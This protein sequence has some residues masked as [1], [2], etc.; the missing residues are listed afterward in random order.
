VNQVKLASLPA[1]R[2]AGDVEMLVKANAASL[3]AW[4]ISLSIFL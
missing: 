2:I 4:R 1:W 3:P